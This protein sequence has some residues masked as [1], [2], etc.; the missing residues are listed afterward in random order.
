MNWAKGIKYLGYLFTG[1]GL[2][3]LSFLVNNDDPDRTANLVYHL[4]IFPDQELISEISDQNLLRNVRS[5]FLTSFSLIG[6]GVV[7]LVF[8]I[9]A[10][11]E[12]EK[13]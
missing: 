1:I 12:K 8:G 10:D 7:L 9:G 11:R 4:V 13:S 2:V 6:I 5:T 3:I